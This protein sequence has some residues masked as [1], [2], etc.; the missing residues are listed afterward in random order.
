MLASTCTVASSAQE[1]L[2]SAYFLEGYNYR[3]ELNPAFA[4]ER[5]YVSFPVLGNLSLGFNSNVGL[6]TFLYPWNGRARHI[7]APRRERERVSRQAPQCQPY[8]AGT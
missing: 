6:S 5:N 4:P 1:A 7:H 2:R 8:P 3:H